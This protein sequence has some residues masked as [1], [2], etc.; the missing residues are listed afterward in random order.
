MA[1]LEPFNFWAD[2]LLAIQCSFICK[3]LF[4]CMLNLSWTKWHRKTYLCC[5]VFLIC[6]MAPPTVLLVSW[7]DVNRMRRHVVAS[8]LEAI[9]KALREGTS[10]DEWSVVSQSGEAA[11]SAEAQPVVFVDQKTSSVTQEPKSGL[12]AE[13]VEQKGGWT[14]WKVCFKRFKGH[15][16]SRGLQ[17]GSS[18]LRGFGQY[19]N[20]QLF[21]LLGGR[22]SWDMAK[23]GADTSTKR[24]GRKRGPA[25]S[26]VRE[27]GGLAVVEQDVPGSSNAGRPCAVR[28]DGEGLPVLR[29][30]ELAAKELSPEELRALGDE[31]YRNQAARWRS[32]SGTKRISAALARMMNALKG[33]KSSWVE[34]RVRLRSLR[35]SRWQQLELKEVAGGKSPWRCF[36]RSHLDS[37]SGVLPQ[38]GRCFAGDG[39]EVVSAVLHYHGDEIGER[40]GSRAGWCPF[41]TLRFDKWSWT[42]CGAATW[43]LDDRVAAFFTSSPTRCN[44]DGLCGC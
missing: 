25:P 10:D 23:V 5:N 32:N 34:D 12:A 15:C 35:L 7:C 31:G 33:I 14:F 21:G 24:L 43:D 41:P 28:G 4:Q 36:T 19:Q 38:V 26:S 11:S 2:G 29:A 3:R 40:S 20:P 17:G 8:A 37:D 6:S 18:F 44:L 1:N 39:C 22:E 16:L 13:E 30:V 9:A 42:S 27:E